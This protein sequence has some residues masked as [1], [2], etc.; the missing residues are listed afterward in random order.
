MIKLDGAFTEH[1]PTG[2]HLELSMQHEQLQTKITQ[3]YGLI[4]LKS[5]HTTAI[6]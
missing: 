6:T 5:K 3:Q 4:Q 1:K 2:H